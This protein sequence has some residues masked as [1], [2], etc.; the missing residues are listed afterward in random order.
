[1][2]TISVTDLIPSSFTYLKNYNFFFRL[3]LITFSFILGIF[4]SYYI[5]LKV[6]KE[7]SNS[8]KKGIISMLVIILHNIPED[9]SC[10]VS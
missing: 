3:L 2:L 8:L 4:L 1:M 10:Y 9:C 5:S 7:Y 6:E